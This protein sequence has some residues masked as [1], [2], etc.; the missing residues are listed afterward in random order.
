M[1][2]NCILCYPEVKQGLY[3]KEADEGAGTPTPA[4]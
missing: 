1:V 3:S 4:R 2:L